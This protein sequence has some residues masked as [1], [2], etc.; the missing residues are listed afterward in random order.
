MIWAP[1]QNK[2]DQ[3]QIYID[4]L[5]PDRFYLNSIWPKTRIWN[6]NDETAIGYKM[7]KVALEWVMIYQYCGF[8]FFFFC[9]HSI[10]NC[11]QDKADLWLA[12]FELH[13]K[14][15]GQNNYHSIARHIPLLTTKNTLTSLHILTIYCY[16]SPPFKDKSELSTQVQTSQYMYKKPHIYSAY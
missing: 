1:K 6:T 4:K 15:Q 8:F 11:V 16:P 12:T 2:C 13:N 9:G 14:T 5:K 10:L 7:E 3:S